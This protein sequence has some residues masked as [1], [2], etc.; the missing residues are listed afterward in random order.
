MPNIAKIPHR[1]KSITANAFHH[2]GIHC[3]THPIRVILISGVVI[4]SLFYPAQELYFSSNSTAHNRVYS[5][6]ASYQSDLRQCC[7]STMGSISVCSLAGFR[8]TMVPWTVHLVMVVFIG[9]ENMFLLIDKVTSTSVSLPVKERMGVGL[10]SAGTTITLNT[11]VYNTIL[12]VIAGFTT[13]AIREFCVF[14]IVLLVAHWFLVHSLFIAVL[15][16]DLQRLELS[17]VLSQDASKPLIPPISD[18]SQHKAPVS[19]RRRAINSIHERLRVIPAKNGS[20]LLM[21]TVTAI[22]YYVTYPIQS[23]P[24]D[25]ADP[26]SF[27]HNAKRQPAPKATPVPTPSLALWNIL[28]PDNDPFVHIRIETPVIVALN[29]KGASDPAHHQDIRSQGRLTR[30][31]IWLFKTMVLP[32]AGT[33]AALYLLLLYLLRG[34]DQLEAHRTRPDTVAKPSVSTLEGQV[35][36]KALPR[37]FAT[38][39]A[40][41]ATNHDGS[42]IAMLST[43]NELTIWNEVYQRL[44]IQCVL[45]NF[46]PSPEANTRITRV[47]MDADGHYCA[48][49]TDTGI[50]AIWQIPRRGVPLDK[51][52]HSVAITLPDAI[53][54]IVFI[55]VKVD[56]MQLNSRP[57]SPAAGSDSTVRKQDLSLLVACDNGAVYQIN[58]MRGS[59]VQ[60]ISPTHFD[61][62]LKGYI[63][64]DTGKDTVYVAYAYQDGVVELLSRTSDEI[65]KPSCFVTAGRHDDPVSHISVTSFTA[66]DAVSGLVLTTV[67]SCGAVTLWDAMTAEVLHSMDSLLGNVIGLRTAPITPQRCQ[68]CGS[69]SPIAMALTILVG[70]TV[71][72]YRAKIPGMTDRCNCPVIQKAFL[73]D[74]FGRR[75]RSSSTASV[76]SISSPPKNRPKLSTMLAPPTSEASEFPVSP[77]GVHPRRSSEK[78]SS[79]RTSGSF[80]NEIFSGGSPGNSTIHPNGHASSAGSLVLEFLADF[81]CERGGWDLIDGHRLIGLRRRSRLQQNGSVNIPITKLV[82]RPGQGE[83][84]ATVLDRWELWAFDPGHPETDVR[85]SSLLVLSN[86]SKAASAPKTQECPRLAFTRVSP[87]ITSSSSCIAGFGNTTGIINLSRLSA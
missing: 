51:V 70:H 77:H 69:T 18:D 68:L 48:I 26:F 15:S 28:N 22:L 35:T 7:A 45:A 62:V 6:F 42:I 31:T 83:L 27:L 78:D 57:Q 20:L 9:A 1:A 34:A 59:S 63:L 36:F 81:S 5:L 13:G 47:V 64:L 23:R 21:L 55:P 65:W 82:S 30:R 19:K 3:A 61:T 80:S 67:T 79:R 33:T 39:V 29:I 74:S 32:I 46:S 43:K 87:I 8:L 41:I 54:D 17:D 25:D 66:S 12:G 72:V 11:V 56:T 58:P 38:D 44:N 49:S 60:P 75:S 37:T 76:N 2:F 86:S 4:L 40:R 85:S 53:L 52:P 14:A 16:I 10:A 73:R 50:L 84:P 71:F 24:T